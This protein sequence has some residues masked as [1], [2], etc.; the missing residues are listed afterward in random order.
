[1]IVAQEQ[2][3]LKAQQ[4]LQA[5]QA[6]VEQAAADGQRIDAVERELFSQ[7]LALGHTLLSAFVAAQGDGNAGNELPAGED[8]HPVRRLQGHPRGLSAIAFSP[9]GKYLAVA[10]YS[11]PRAIVL[12]AVAMGKEVHCDLDRETLRS[13]APLQTGGTSAG[14]IAEVCR[15]VLWS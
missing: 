13:L 11:E 10:F 12:W 7:L 3:F 1:M 2:A 4:Q 8:P 9:D 5:L 14:R 15:E 6:Q